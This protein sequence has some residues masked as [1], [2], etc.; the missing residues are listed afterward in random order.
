[1]LMPGMALCRIRQRAPTMQ[2]GHAGLTG[3]GAATVGSTVGRDADR[4]KRGLLNFDF[5][6]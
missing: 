2:R 5:N 3:A 6:C 1:M 4:C